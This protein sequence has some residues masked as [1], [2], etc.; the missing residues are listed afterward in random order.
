MASF[1]FLSPPFPQPTSPTLPLPPSPLLHNSPSPPLPAHPALLLASTGRVNFEAFF[2]AA[3]PAGELVENPAC[4][5]SYFSSAF[6]SSSLFPFSVAL[7]SKS[8]NLFY[9]SLVILL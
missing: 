6:S 2:D 7:Y 3:F 5:S 4:I 8:V 9:C 1:L